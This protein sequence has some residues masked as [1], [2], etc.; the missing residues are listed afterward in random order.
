MRTLLAFGLACGLLAST[1]ALAEKLDLSKVK[2]DDFLKQDKDFHGQIL[3]WLTAY[4]MSED[5][6]PIVDFDKVVE[7]GKKLGAYCVQNP[8][9]GLITAWDTASK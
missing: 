5:D 8:G 4:S 6:E 7:N 9:A 3:M 2:C 1:P